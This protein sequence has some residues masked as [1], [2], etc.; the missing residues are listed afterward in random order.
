MES[1][2][3]S[4][5]TYENRKAKLMPAKPMHTGLEVEKQP[6]TPVEAELFS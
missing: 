2:A 3:G 1:S 5:E 6:S 4:R